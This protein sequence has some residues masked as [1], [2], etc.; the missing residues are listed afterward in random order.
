MLIDNSR[1]LLLLNLSICSENTI[2]KT[3][4]SVHKFKFE[5]YILLIPIAARGIIV[6]QKFLP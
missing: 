2:H 4:A 3:Y 6:D 5:S 1:H